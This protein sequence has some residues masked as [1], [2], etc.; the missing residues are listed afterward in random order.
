MCDR[1]QTLKGIRLSPETPGI[2]KKRDAEGGTHLIGASKN[3][4]SP[5][6]PVSSLEKNLLLVLLA[7]RRSPS[8]PA[9]LLGPWPGI[10]APGEGRG[11]AAPGRSV[12]GRPEKAGAGGGA[13]WERGPLECPRSSW[14]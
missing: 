12:P 10:S 6:V 3:R 11:G 9:V 2:G 5:T 13:R 1:T 4:R 8:S 7:H 14:P